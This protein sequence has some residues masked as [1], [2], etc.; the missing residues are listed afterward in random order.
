MTRTSI[1][2]SDFIMVYTNDNEGLTLLTY[3]IFFLLIV[4]QFTALRRIQ[5]LEDRLDKQVI[6]NYRIDYDSDIDP[7]TDPTIH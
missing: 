2:E 5:V 7:P 3:T 1:L 4:I 6:F